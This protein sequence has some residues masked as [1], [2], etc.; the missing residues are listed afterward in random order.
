MTLLEVRASD[1]VVHA[2]ATALYDSLAARPIRVQ[3]ARTL[4][5]AKPYFLR[6]LDLEAER[7]RRFV[8]ADVLVVPIV[9]EDGTPGIF[10]RGDVA[11]L[12]EALNP[13][14]RP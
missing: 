5:A 4:Y 8:G 7:V 13:I 9:D 3:R 12:I 11:Y 14:T 10:V 2:L 1:P 6:D